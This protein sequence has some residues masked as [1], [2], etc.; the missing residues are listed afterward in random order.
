MTASTQTVSQ[1]PTPTTVLATLQTALLFSAYT[2]NLTALTDTLSLFP[3]QRARIVLRA[4]R[5]ILTTQAMVRTAAT[6]VHQGDAE[7]DLE[8]LAHWVRWAK[9]VVEQACE[10][11]ARVAGKGNGGV[12]LP[13]AMRAANGT[14][15]IHPTL[16]AEQKKRGAVMVWLE[17]LEAAVVDSNQAGPVGLGIANMLELVE[18]GSES[19][20]SFSTQPG[21]YSSGLYASAMRVQDGMALPQRRESAL[22]ALW[23]DVW[24]ASAKSAKPADAKCSRGRQARAAGL[25]GF[26]ADD[27]QR[28]ALECEHCFD[29][30]IDG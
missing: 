6:A 8:Q 28:H 12:N 26:F 30:L 10:P 29:S 9:G 15:A 19:V 24:A 21:L 27:F 17:G 20:L 18:E 16:L 2:L 1:P 14:S 7:A 5:A 4:W 13:L 11:S 22:E 23:E 25:H 3:N